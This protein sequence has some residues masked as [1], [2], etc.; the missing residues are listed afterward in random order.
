MFEIRSAS[1]T[2]EFVL[3]SI[4]KEGFD[5]NVLD[6]IVDIDY[7]K[8]KENISKG[9][10]HLTIA[11]KTIESTDII[12]Y[13]TDRFKKRY[14]QKGTKNKFVFETYN[15]RSISTSNRSG[16]SSI[17]FFY[18]YNLFEKSKVKGKVFETKGK[19][20]GYYG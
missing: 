8:V 4:Q 2:K 7:I 13:F 17:T 9:G 6:M 19:T 10:Y 20:R 15:W 12:E 14:S 1:L 5:R 16:Y 18:R 11:Q 3:K